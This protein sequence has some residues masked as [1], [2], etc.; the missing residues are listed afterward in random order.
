MFKFFAW[1]KITEY[2]ADLNAMRLRTNTS[3]CW[4]ASVWNSPALNRKRYLA[5]LWA[6]RIVRIW[7]LGVSGKRKGLF[8][9]FLNY[10]V[11]VFKIQI[12][13]FLQAGLKKKKDTIIAVWKIAIQKGSIYVMWIRDYYEWDPMSHWSNWSLPMIWLQ[14]HPFFVLKL[15]PMYINPILNHIM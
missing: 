2:I 12:G 13:S 11:K 7:D 15:K 8:M 5:R 9:Q 10:H 4:T 6:R 14:N 1:R 3:T